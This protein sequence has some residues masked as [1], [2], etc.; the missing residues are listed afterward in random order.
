LLAHYFI[1]DDDENASPVEGISHSA[2]R[3][4]MNHEWRG[5]VGTLRIVITQAKALAT[6]E[7]RKVIS[8]S[9][10][11]EIMTRDLTAS[12]QV[13]KEKPSDCFPTLEEIEK[14]HILSAWRR[15]ITTS[16]LPPNSSAS[17]GRR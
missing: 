8:L 16:R 11:P 2:L 13:Q 14:S 7:G 3:A 1:D 6:A 10:L 5:N 12:P 4:L 17:P 15:P 9:D